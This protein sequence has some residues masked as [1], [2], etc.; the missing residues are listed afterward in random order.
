M[1]TMYNENC[2]MYNEHLPV[3]S[4]SRSYLWPSQVFTSIWPE[5]QEVSDSLFQQFVLPECNY[6]GRSFKRK[7]RT[8]Q[9]YNFSPFPSALLA[10]WKLWPQSALLYRMEKN[11]GNIS[12]NKDKSCGRRCQQ[13]KG[14]ELIALPPNLMTFLMLH[15]LKTPP[16]KRRTEL[17]I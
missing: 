2:T 5:L 15:C 11:V 4:E 14:M 13:Y 7:I 6:L 1:R 12:S 17:S 8:G 16:V 10:H 9:K 3:Q